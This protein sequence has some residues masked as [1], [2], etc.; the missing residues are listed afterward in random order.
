MLPGALTTD[1]S[2]CIQGKLAETILKASPFR[3]D[4][5]DRS[6]TFGRDVVVEHV[7]DRPPEY[8][9]VTCSYIPQKMLVFDWPGSAVTLRI[10][11]YVED[12]LHHRFTSEMFGYKRG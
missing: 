8:I 3:S 1:E 6:S 10:F 4:G 7:S 11:R 9:W 5:V 12:L 2:L